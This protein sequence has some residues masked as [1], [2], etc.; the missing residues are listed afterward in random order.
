MIDTDFLEINKLSDLYDG[1]NIFFCKTDYL[2]N[3]FEQISKL[4]NNVVL[5]SGNSDYAITDKIFN[6]KP[7]NIIA[8]YAQNALVNSSILH[9]LPIGLENKL[10]SFRAGHGVGYYNRACQ[11][12]QIL[13]QL[14][15]NSYPEKF[16]YSNFNIFTNIQHRDLIKKVC[17][18]TSYID[19]E[20]PSLSLKAMYSK[21][22]EYKMVIC[23]AGNGIDT[24]RLW[25]ILYCNRIPITFKMGSY[26]IYELYKK[27]PIIILNKIEDLQNKNLIKEN[28]NKEISKIK[29]YQYHQYLS[30][31]YWKNLIINSISERKYI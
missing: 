19:W 14:S 30:C 3:D 10:P 4:N 8:W 16:I 26:K 6:L 2:L 21:I 23:P 24:H 15:L 31:K 1:K 28:Y 17:L 27:L 9:P 29:Y 7:S 13:S 5:V 22:L 25:E 18:K 12:E 11:R 20:E